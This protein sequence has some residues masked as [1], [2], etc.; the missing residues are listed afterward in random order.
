MDIQTLL[1][2]MSAYRHRN[3]SQAAVENYISQ[4]SLS[5]NIAKLES[6]LGVVLFER[7]NK[8]LVP[9]VAGDVFFGYANKM[10]SLASEARSRTREAAGIEK[11]KLVI[12]ITQATT[13]RLVPRLVSRYA[14]KY[15]EIELE[16]VDY[17][18]LS[19]MYQDIIE[20]KIQAGPTGGNYRVREQGIL[21]QTVGFER[22][23]CSVDANSSFA[24]KEFLRLE[25]FRGHGVQLPVAGLMY[26][27]DALKRYIK[28]HEPEITVAETPTGST[29]MLQ[30]L[31]AGYAAFGP[32]SFCFP[33]QGKTYVPFMPPEG[34]DKSISIDI[35]VRSLDDPVIKS[36]CE[37]A[38]QVMAEG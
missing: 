34:I 18:S 22:P 7:T 6:D 8:G 20:G 17:A 31:R 35:A 27:H 23:L 19:D 38:R 21:F 14:E 24:K 36:F 10:T 11:T 13:V 26:W 9:T 5:K 33:L 30:A 1:Y 15:P 37:T 25:D 4:Q 12:G 29:G 2:F 16:F 32:E 28:E 3:L